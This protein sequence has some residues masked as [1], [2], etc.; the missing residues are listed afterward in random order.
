MT[1]HWTN[2]LTRPVVLSGRQRGALTTLIEGAEFLV[3]RF[4]DVT[5]NPELASCMA[6]IMSAASTGLRSDAEA[7]TDHLTRVLASRRMLV[8]H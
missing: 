3:S 2:P 6:A 1:D 7:A 8:V 4:C 5:K